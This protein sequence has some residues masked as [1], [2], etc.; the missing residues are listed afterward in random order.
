[1]RSKVS[2]EKEWIIY[3]HDKGNM[4]HNSLDNFGSTF[5]YTDTS[6]SNFS[7]TTIHEIKKRQVSYLNDKRTPCQS[8]PRQAEMN[9]CI[10]QYIESEIGCQLPW[11]NASSSSACTES[12]QYQEFLTTYD[13]I[14]KLSERSIAERT[15]CLPSCQ[16]NE[17]TVK[18]LNRIENPSDTRGYYTGYFYYASGR[19]MKKSHHY[20]YDLFDLLADV[21][22]YMGLLVGYS[23]LSVYDSIKY[24][25]KKVLIVYLYAINKY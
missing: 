7:L 6:S 4:L 1:M 20:E 22:G 10:Q 12:H 17:F 25:C 18:I 5:S 11:N 13:K 14:A 9:T 16:R 19:Y 23:L 15:G 3:I 24:F 2:K 21:G 8:K